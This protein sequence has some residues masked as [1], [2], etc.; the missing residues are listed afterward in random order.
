MIPELLSYSRWYVSIFRKCILKIEK[1]KIRNVGQVT[2]S[3]PIVYFS[4]TEIKADL[5]YEANR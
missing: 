3:R 1:K 2:I 5:N 4:A